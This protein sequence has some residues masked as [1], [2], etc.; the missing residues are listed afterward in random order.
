MRILVL[1]CGL[2]G[3]VIAKDC[4]EDNEVAKIVGCDFDEEQL[5]KCS[6]FV[7]NRKFGT[8][9]LD[10]TDYETLVDKL[11]SFDVAINASAAQFSSHILKAAVKAGVNLVDLS[12]VWYPLDGDIYTRVERAEITVI[13]GCGV[14]PGLADIL[15]GYAIDLMDEVETVSFSCGGLPKNPTPPLDYKIVF[16]GKKMPIRRGTVPV[17]LDGTPVTVE[18][19]DGVEPVHVPGF[20]DMEAFYDGYPSRLLTLCMEKGVKTF[21]GKTIRYAG[22]VKKLKFLSDLGII[23][24]EPVIYQGHKIIPLDFFHELVY[25][26]VKFNPEYDRDVTILLVEVEGKKGNSRMHVTFEMIDFYDEKTQITS[27]ARTTGYTAAIVARMLARGDISEKGI[28]W[29]VQIIKGK[30]FEELM[31]NLKKRGIKVAKNVSET[32]EL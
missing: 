1:G 24:E 14:D 25:P 17:I 2:M 23:R 31:D 10:L 4:T 27:M 7:S 13:P 22:F 28:Q 9:K 21:V 29:P 18:R 8:S 5:R 15:S 6:K 20:E 12:G 19:Y 11:D 30:L 32:R 3:P 26:L 16:G